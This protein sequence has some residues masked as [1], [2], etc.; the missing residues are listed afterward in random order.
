M[1]SN[2]VEIIKKNVILHTRQN[3]SGKIGFLTI[4]RMAFN[5]CN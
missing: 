5:I 3:L 2:Q 4:L 1:V